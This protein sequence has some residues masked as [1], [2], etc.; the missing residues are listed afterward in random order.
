M[1]C[2]V[3]LNMYDIEGKDKTNTLTEEMKKLNLKKHSGGQSLH[4]QSEERNFNLTLQSLINISDEN[5]IKLFDNLK[6]KREIPFDFF[7]VYSEYKRNSLS[8]NKIHPLVIGGNYIML[9]S[10]LRKRLLN[11]NN[12]K[13]YDKNDKY[14]SLDDI[15]K[16][17]LKDRVAYKNY[18]KE[19]NS[20]HN[21]YE[22]IKEYIK[23]ELNSQNDLDKL[24]SLSIKNDNNKENVLLMDEKKIETKVEEMYEKVVI[25]DL[26]EIMINNILDN[27]K[28]YMA[29]VIV[30]SERLNNL[31]D[32][33]IE[34]NEKFKI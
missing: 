4:S 13:E 24:K 14:I 23:S 27:K 7:L 34:H 10:M 6:T 5:R 18:Q 30:R 22:D 26:N 28:I 15:S 33:L 20:K 8:G 16:L 3:K 31:Y 32:K 1:E 2:L 19:M 12:N 25:Q 11:K 29:L 17:S 9:K 21:I